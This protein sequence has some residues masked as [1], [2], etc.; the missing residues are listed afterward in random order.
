MGGLANLQSLSLWGNQLTGEIPTEFG[1]LANLEQLRL[2]QNKL[3]GPIPTELGGLANLQSLSLWGNQLTGEI[4]TEFGNLANLEQLR[5]HYN[6]LS[7]VVPQTL[8][9]LTMLEHFSF[10]NN[11]GLCAPIDDAFQIWLRGISILHGSSCA[12]ADSPE[13]RAVLVEVHSTTDGVN[14]TNQRQ[15]AERRFNQAMVRGYE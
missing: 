15:L 2:S 7:G 8:A 14:W 6:E 11:L 5:L 12:Q 3:T 10:Y 1:N 13:D 4:P 9:G